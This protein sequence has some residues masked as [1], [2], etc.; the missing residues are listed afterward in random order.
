MSNSYV[1][2]WTVARQVPLS[3]GFPRQEY[4]SG[5]PF[6]SPGDL[7]D[8]RVEPT[9]PVLQADFLPLSYRGSP[10][11]YI[12]TLLYIYIYIYICSNTINYIH[13]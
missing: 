9:S 7:P 1:T 11:T 3:M 5:L 6:L 13:I 2:P 8:P 12:A 4:W 10:N